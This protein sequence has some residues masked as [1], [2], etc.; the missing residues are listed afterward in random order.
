MFLEISLFQGGTQVSKLD[1]ADILELTVS[2][3]RHIQQHQKSAAMATQCSIKQEYTSGYREAALDSLAYLNSRGTASVN[4]DNNSNKNLNRACVPE[5]T[6][7]T[8]NRYMIPNVS[9]LEQTYNANIEIDNY[10]PATDTN[11]NF[12]EDRLP[13]SNISDGI[14]THFVSVPKGRDIFSDST[15]TSAETKQYCDSVNEFSNVFTSR[16]VFDL[17]GNIDNTVHGLNNMRNT[18]ESFSTESAV[19]EDD[20]SDAD[21][22]EKLRI[23]E[24][25]DNSAETNSNNVERN[26][27]QRDVENEDNHREDVWRPW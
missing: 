9:D 10:L 15:V 14:R 5:M 23:Y 20:D 25:V 2:Y 17:N 6:S 7:L 18:I 13:F 1:K 16:N 19:K 26:I 22:E 24:P 3:L 12:A 4:V 21:D 27:I 8:V 11:G